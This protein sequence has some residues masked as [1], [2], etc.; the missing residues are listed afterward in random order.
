MIEIVAVGSLGLATSRLALGCMGMSEFYVG[1][2]QAASKAT[3]HEAVAQGITMFDTADM[4]GP[5]QN[6]HLVGDCLRPYRE[7]VV[8][9]TKF[10][11]VRLPDGTRLGLSG[12]PDYVKSAC[13]A[14]L[15]RLKTDYIDLYYLHRVDRAIA[16]EDT[17]AAMARLVEEGK[18]RFI[19][20]S[21]V[22][23]GTL[24]RAHAVF[25]VSAVQS[26]YSLLSRDPE[27]DLFDVLRELNIGF[28]AY[29]PLG[30]GLLTG[31]FRKIE[32]IPTQ[33]YRRTTPRFSGDNLKHNVS[34][35]DLLE[36]IGREI[37]ATR[38]QVALAWV[39]EKIGNA[40]VLVG[41]TSAQRLREN[42]F[43][44][45]VHL[46]SAFLDALDQMFHREAT[47]GDRYSDMSRVNG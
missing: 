2:T 28:V 4:Y 22:S 32:D 27:F 36:K 20:L 25:P 13:E 18:V 33:D 19:G 24:R 16:I 12:H 29:A 31:R 26:E 17:V 30:R 47:H 8:I 40:V 45:S 41:T 5:F 42:V 23:A 39:R 35:G 43:S 38:A 15:R 37:G 6:E 21:E 34:L 7:K 1:S 3:I 9:A 46:D 11:Y 14:S 44:F 10:G